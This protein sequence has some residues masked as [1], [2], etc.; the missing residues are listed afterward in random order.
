M[1]ANRFLIAFS[2]VLSVPF[3]A[4]STPPSRPSVPDDGRYT[5]S[6][7]KL[8]A[9]WRSL[10]AQSGIV[11]YRLRPL[12][13]RDLGRKHRAEKGSLRIGSQVS[14]I[15]VQELFGMRYQKEIETSSSMLA[16]T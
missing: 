3:A 11:E 2:V 14:A 15:P 4:D 12:R 6:S 10:D 1:I 5:S 16:E 9:M 8:H 13:I 7:V